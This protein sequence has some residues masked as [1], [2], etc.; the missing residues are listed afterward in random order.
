MEIPHI[1]F[2]RAIKSEG[3]ILNDKREYIVV[4]RS[5]LSYILCAAPF[6]TSF[7]ISW[8]QGQT[9]GFAQRMLAGIPV[10]GPALERVFCKQTYYHEDTQLMF[11]DTVHG[12]VIKIVDAMA[13]EKGVRGPSELER[14][15]IM[16]KR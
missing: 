15:P 5:S 10:F 12:L 4:S 7:F 11:R 2:E 13:L 8:R 14:K 1:Y 3:G 16:A 6:G 9:R